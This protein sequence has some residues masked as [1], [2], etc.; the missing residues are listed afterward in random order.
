MDWLKA[1]ICCCVGLL[2]DGAL[3][4]LVIPNRYG[5]A[6]CGYG[7]FDGAASSWKAW[8]FWFLLY[9]VPCPCTSLN[10]LGLRFRSFSSAAVQ[11]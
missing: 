8:D 3:S 7:R 4:E 2:V 6:G 1:S 10:L 9:S 5:N 11:V